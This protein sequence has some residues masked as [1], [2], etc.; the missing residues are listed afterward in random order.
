MAHVFAHRALPVTQGS[1][2][3][4]CSVVLNE[5]NSFSTLTT[6]DLERIFKG[7]QVRSDFHNMPNVSEYPNWM[8]FRRNDM[9][10]TDAIYRTVIAIKSVTQSKMRSRTDPTTGKPVSFES[11]KWV[12]EV[13]G[14]YW[15]SGTWTAGDVY[16]EIDYLAVAGTMHEDPELRVLAMPTSGYQALHEVLGFLLKPVAA[17]VPLL[18]PWQTALGFANPNSA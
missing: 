9:T 7:Q 18:T 6:E 5:A 4:Q 1:T 2:I 16:N 3:I 10:G 11:K 13:R 17:G 12:T 15:V 14:W 8:F